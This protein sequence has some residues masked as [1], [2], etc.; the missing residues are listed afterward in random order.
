MLPTVTLA[1]LSPPD[2]IVGAAGAAAATIVNVASPDVAPPGFSTSTNAVPAAAIRPAGTTAD[3][4]VALTYT[5][6]S[7]CAPEPEFHCT[8]DP[9]TKFVPFTT[10]WKAAPP[11]VRL[12]GESV[13]TVGV[14]T[15][16]AL[17]V[18]VTMFDV[19]PPG[20]C[21]VI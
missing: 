11:A 3:S 20:F 8:T 17:T 19:A 14:T 16:A 5:L 9:L 2:P 10:S 12:A 7:V 15:A 18:N 4:C 1:G 6:D 21:T 13:V